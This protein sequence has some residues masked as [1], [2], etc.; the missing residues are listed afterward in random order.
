M[1]EVKKQWLPKVVMTGTSDFESTW[2]E[3][4]TTLTTQVDVK[5]YEEELTKE[6]R[7]RV[8]LFNK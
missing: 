8:E 6:A 4:Q 2:N 5:A 7:R 3:Y 1:D